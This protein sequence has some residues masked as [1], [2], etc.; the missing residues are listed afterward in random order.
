MKRRCDKFDAYHDTDT[1]EWLE[2]ACSDPDCELCADRPA[3][4]T[5]SCECMVEVEE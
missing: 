1:G 5:D 2:Q 3:V 4:H